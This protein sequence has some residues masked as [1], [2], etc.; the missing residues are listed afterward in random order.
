M[1]DFDEVLFLSS[2]LSFFLTGVGMS[3]YSTPDN[4]TSGLSSNRLTGTTAG[5]GKKKMPEKV[6]PRKRSRGNDVMRTPN[7]CNNQLYV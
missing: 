7:F 3:G 5:P 6:E 4:C 2:M 1:C